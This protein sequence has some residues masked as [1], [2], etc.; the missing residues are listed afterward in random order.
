M[1]ERIQLFFKDQNKLAQT[2]TVCFFI[3]VGFTAY[4]LWNLRYDLVYKGGM[5]DSEGAGGVLAKLS[6]VVGLAFAFCYAMIFLFQRIKKE[7]IVYLDKKIDR[8]ESTQGSA[9]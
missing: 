7:T 9:G 3:A 8:T 4:F 2:A 1:I 5:V 6:I